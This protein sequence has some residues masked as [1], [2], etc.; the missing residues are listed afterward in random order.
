MSTKATND[1]AIE[2][3]LSEVLC[4]ASCLKRQIH[5]VILLVVLQLAGIAVVRRCELYILEAIVKV[6][7]QMTMQ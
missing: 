7:Y 6:M 1:A 5:Y 2:L 4:D 3:V